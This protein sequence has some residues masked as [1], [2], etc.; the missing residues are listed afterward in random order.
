MHPG[1]GLYAKAAIHLSAYG[2][3]LYVLEK[4]R[5]SDI[6][7]LFPIPGNGANGVINRADCTQN[8]INQYEFMHLDMIVIQRQQ[9]PESRLQ[10]RFDNVLLLH[11]PVNHH[12][13]TPLCQIPV[14]F[15][16]IIAQHRAKRK[17]VRIQPVV[18]W[19]DIG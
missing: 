8:H 13:I 10:Q 3:L 15:A 12:I 5:G 17:T 16:V 14:C 18:Q 7:L 6:F 11:F 1:Q 2:C 19:R 4:V 9:R